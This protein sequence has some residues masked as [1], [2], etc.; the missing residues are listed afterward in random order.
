MRGDVTGNNEVDI[1]DVT[2]LIGYLLNG[3]GSSLNLANADCTLNGEIDISDVTALINYL[4]SGDDSAVNVIAADCN[5]DGN[6]N[7]SDVTTLINYL[8]SGNWS[9]GA[10]ARDIKA[11]PNAPL[12]LINDMELV[13]EE[14]VLGVRR[15]P[16]LTLRR[17]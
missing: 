10:K 3:D 4:L 17:D 16:D 13:M 14:P 2:A 11:E 12:K 6:V 7:I 1:S 5:Q 8:L 15:S 9:N